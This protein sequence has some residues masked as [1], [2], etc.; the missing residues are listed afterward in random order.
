MSLLSWPMAALVGGL[1]IPA[2]LLLYFL[3]LR[4]MERKV[5]S[6]LLWK[7]AVEDL[8]VNAPFQK[9]RKNLL[10]FL[11]LLILAAVLFA[12]ANPV[13]NFMRKPEETVVLLMD[14]SAS[15]KSKEAD[16]RRRLEHAQDAA[17]A[18]IEDLPKGSRAMVISF[19]DKPEIVSSFTD[20]KRRL[21]ASIDRI[22]AGDGPSRIGEAMQLAIAYSSN[23]VDVPGV[24][25]PL[26]AQAAADLEL[27]SDGRIEDAADQFLTRGK[28]RY[29][30]VGEAADNVGIVTFD[31]RRDLERP[32]ILSIFAQIENFGPAAVKTDV[33]LLLDGKE[34]SGPGS[35]REVS[36]G[37]ALQSSTGASTQPSNPRS[38]ASLPSSQNIIFELQHEAAGIIE[39]KV[40]R[41]DAFMVDNSAI[42][43]IDPPRDLRILLVSDR[44]PIQFAIQKFM[45]GIEMEGL[46]VMSGEEYE[47]AKDE[48]LILEGRSAFDLVIFENHDSTRLPPGSYIFFGGIPQIDG[49]ARGEEIDGSP[50]VYGAE[51]HPLIRNVNYESLFIAKWHRMTMPS[52]A[53]SLLEGESSPVMWM[54]TEPGHRYVITAFDLMES[55]FLFSGNSY[56]FPVFMQN[57]LGY[58]AGGGLVESKRLLGPGDSF[59]MSVPPGAEKVIIRR[60]GGQTEDID[61]HERNLITFARTAEVGVY[62]A[63]FDD[64]KKTREVFAVNLLKPMES[65]IFPRQDFTVGS[66]KV[67]S[68]SAE[69]KVNEPLWPY[70]VMVA[71]A[72]LM[73]EWWVYNRRVMI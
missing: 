65:N 31:V 54:L 9:L 41:T 37:P 42:A 16:G 47:K 69:T 32:G 60:P 59:S 48:K 13:M 19:A 43:P 30:R 22:E 50:L 24:S 70:A 17:R 1:A 73:L 40:H 46:E 45:N 38:Q 53:Q 4:R 8:R 64:N 57:A 28:M 10:L 67:V 72:I 36:L 49:I 62:S 58:L 18:M 63:E 6:T 5:S 15:M 21:K 20:D 29:Y 66:E 7:R 26:S 33:S 51:N 14:R 35:V 2:L 34:L 52:H 25:T 44:K 27:F 23:L 55:D 3:K 12:M 71:M 61:V 11:Q 39:V 68:V 56:A